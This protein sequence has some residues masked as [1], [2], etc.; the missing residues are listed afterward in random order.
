MIN[1]IFIG[2]G[3]NVNREKNILAVIDRL[4]EHFT[5]IKL[6]SVYETSPVGDSEANNYFNLVGAYE[7]DLSPR[8]AIKLLKKIEKIC[9][10][11]RKNRCPMD[12]DLLLY[13]DLIDHNDEIDLP[14]KDI[15]QFA[16]VAVPLAE[17]NGEQIHPETRKTFKQHSQIAD[18]KVW[19]ANFEI[20]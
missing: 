5:E 10:Q 1:R 9:G 18:Q 2:I 6:S 15:I 8:Q 4:K 14:R 13:N 12:L 17:I 19:L 16:Y 7:T 20:Q 11:R 3:S